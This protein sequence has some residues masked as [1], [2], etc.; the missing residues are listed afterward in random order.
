MHTP[1][2][3]HTHTHTHTHAWIPRRHA[4]PRQTTTHAHSIHW[5]RSQSNG[6]KFSRGRTRRLSTFLTAYCATI[7]R[8]GCQQPRLCSTPFSP[9]LCRR[10]G[11]GCERLSWMLTRRCAVRPY[12]LHV[13]TDAPPP[14]TAAQAQKRKAE[15]EIALPLGLLPRR[16][17]PCGARRALALVASTSFGKNAI[18]GAGPRAEWRQ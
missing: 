7:P 6:A 11:R 9:R 17:R 10:L 18:G 3:T 4:R 8:G 14:V 15:A 1:N 13:R 2:D 5:S 12:A 16:T